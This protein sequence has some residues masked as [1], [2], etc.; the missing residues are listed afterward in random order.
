MPALLPPLFSSR[1]NGVANQLQPERKDGNQIREVN[2]VD[3]KPHESNAG[4]DYALGLAK[5]K[6]CAIIHLVGF[7]FPRKRGLS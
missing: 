7:T 6:K 4:A 3:I 5:V 1:A 2:L